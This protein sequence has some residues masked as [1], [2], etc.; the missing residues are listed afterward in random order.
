MWS[1]TLACFY[2]LMLFLLLIISFLILLNYQIEIHDQTTEYDY[3][4]NRNPFL[5]RFHL[6]CVQHLSTLT[7]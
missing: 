1:F 4:K 5:K 2:R 3:K 7:S 6:S